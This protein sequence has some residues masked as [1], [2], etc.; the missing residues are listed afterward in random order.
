MQRSPLRDLI[1]GVFVFFGLI[2][3]RIPLDQGGWS[4]LQRPQRLQARR[5]LR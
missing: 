1:V 5:D 4:L 2:F 3:D